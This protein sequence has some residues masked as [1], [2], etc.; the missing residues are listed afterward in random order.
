[1]SGMY[2]N[3]SNVRN[4]PKDLGAFQTLVAGWEQVGSR[5]HDWDLP[6]S[7]SVS[8]MNEISI[9]LPLPSPTNTS[10]SLALKEQ[11][12]RDLSPTPAFTPALTPTP[13]TPYSSAART[14]T[15]PTYGGSTY[16]FAGVERLAQRQ[17]IYEPQISSPEAR[18]E[19]LS[20]SFEL[21]S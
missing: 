10:K 8:D 15:T 12:L 2:T 14:P 9:G 18:K 19:D 3:A 17:K 1:M 5:S 4:V 6:N 21:I 7:T 20:V 13:T 11:F 16:R